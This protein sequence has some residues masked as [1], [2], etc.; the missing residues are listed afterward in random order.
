MEVWLSCGLATRIVTPLGLNHLS[1]VDSPKDSTGMTKPN[2]LPPT[3]DEEELH[4]RSVTFWL[5]FMADRFA[6][7][8]TGWAM[9]L[10]E[11]DITTLLPSPG[12]IYPETDLSASPLSPRNP[13][14]LISHPPHLVEGF[15]LFMKAVVLLGRVVTFLQREF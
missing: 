1:S 13:N 12:N 6:S 3:S 8:S 15:Q 5:A 7:A 10:D 4:E 14:F 2:L 11:T 9:S